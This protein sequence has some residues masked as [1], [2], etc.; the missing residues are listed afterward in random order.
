VTDDEV[1][2]IADSIPGWRTEEE[3]RALLDAAKG[4]VAGAVIVEVGVFMGRSTLLLAHSLAADPSGT[5]HCID[6]FDCSGDAFSVPHYEALLASS[7]EPD[8][9]SAF[10]ASMVAHSVDPWVRVHVGDACEIGAGWSTPIDLL[11]LDADQSVR[12]ARRTYEAWEPS[13]RI[14]G[15]IVLSNTY[16]REYAEDH[17]GYYRLAAEDI[18]APKYSEVRR[19]GGLTIARK[20]A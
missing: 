12:E 1:V 2:A 9:L 4:L 17:D 19:E 20:Q 5:V 18:R 15:V 3:A 14:G 11:M 13:L 10:R 6:A 8:V 7:A 16:E